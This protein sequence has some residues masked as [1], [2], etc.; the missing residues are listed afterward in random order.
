MI[1]THKFENNDYNSKLDNCSSNSDNYNSSPKIMCPHSTAPV[2]PKANPKLVEFLTKL[3]KTNDDWSA[4]RKLARL[5]TTAELL[6]ASC[7]LTRISLQPCSLA[8]GERLTDTASILEVLQDYDSFTIALDCK[9]NTPK[10][11]SSLNLVYL[12]AT[13]SILTVR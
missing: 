9:F 13:A 7:K 3:P 4:G 6:E 1:T 10:I 11:Q 5:D 12:Q 8:T 2:I